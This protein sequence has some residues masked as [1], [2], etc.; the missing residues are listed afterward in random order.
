MRTLPTL[1]TLGLFLSF[2]AW[3]ST[4][5]ESQ[6]SP[7]LPAL[8]AARPASVSARTEAITTVLTAESASPERS[9][10]ERALL[11]GDT[12]ESLRLLDGTEEAD[13]Y[14]AIL[15]TIDASSELRETYGRAGPMLSDKI[16]LPGEK[17]AP[18]YKSLAAR[19]V[20][21]LKMG[22]LMSAPRSAPGMNEGAA[23][24]L[25]LQ[26]EKEEPANAFYPLFRLLVESR[27]GYPLDQLRATAE[28]AASATTL[29]SHLTEIGGELGNAM[30]LNSA[31]HAALADYHM[32]PML[33][34]YAVGHVLEKLRKDAGF[35]GTP[36]I[37]EL[38]AEEGLRAEKG[39]R[40]G[41]LDRERF[42]YA[43]VLEPKKFPDYEELEHARGW[44]RQQQNWPLIIHYEKGQRRCD[45]T[46][47]DAYF[48][49][50]RP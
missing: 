35:R 10:L 9:A 46:A 25:L 16:Y 41:G 1:F 5:G 18:Q 28:V 48:L 37:A 20:W 8:P 12:C 14:G 7:S 30:W 15:D 31:F 6:A 39:W 47:T 36:R 17:G 32:P 27:L 13:F 38:M 29:D 22:G 43:H 44:D 26:L 4:R 49:Q 2:A 50:V 33:H 3:L 34:W 21:A 23:R 11:A 24:E 40:E 42:E 45:A 19:T